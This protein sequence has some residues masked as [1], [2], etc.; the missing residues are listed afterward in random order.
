M[1]FDK[2]SLKTI[3]GNLLLVILITAVIVLVAVIIKA[4]LSDE[5]IGKKDLT[6]SA[7]EVIRE[8]KQSEKDMSKVIISIQDDIAFIKQNCVKNKDGNTSR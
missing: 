2:N 1:K 4:R 7:R 8:L 3:G 5:T 6:H